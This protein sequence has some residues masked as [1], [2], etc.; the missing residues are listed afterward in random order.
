[1]SVESA[2]TLAMI[3]TIE[4]LAVMPLYNTMGFGYRRNIV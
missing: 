2:G 1:M 4:E 3:Y